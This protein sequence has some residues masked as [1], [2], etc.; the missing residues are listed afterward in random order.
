MEN[1]EELFVCASKKPGY[2][3][4]APQTDVINI[5]IKVIDVND[6]P[7]FAKKVTEVYQREEDEPGKKLFEP[8]ITDEDSDVDKIRWVALHA[9]LVD[10]TQ[11]LSLSLCLSDSLPVTMLYN[12]VYDT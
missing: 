2:K 6:P 4:V 8:V 1:E 10:T 3:V 5:T 9:T 12:Q 7:T 11:P